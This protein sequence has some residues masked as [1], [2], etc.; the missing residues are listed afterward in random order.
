MSDEKAR[1]REIVEQCDICIPGAIQCGTT[2]FDC[3]VSIIATAIAQ[4]RADAL[5]EA[6]RT[7]DSIRAHLL[8]DATVERVAKAID[9][10]SCQHV[11]APDWTNEARAALAAIME[12]QS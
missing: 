4:A 1:A 9:A 3:V 2:S 5:E 7:A 12:D 11:D 8:S 6:A 10:A